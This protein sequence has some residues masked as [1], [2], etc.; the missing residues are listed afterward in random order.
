MSVDYDFQI[1]QYLKEH[2]KTYADLADRL[3]GMV[4]CNNIIQRYGITLE[5]ENGSD[6]DEEY[7]EYY[8]VFQ[9]YII[10]DRDA[11]FLTDYTN[12]LVYYDNELDIYV[13]GIT[14]F[15]TPWAGVPFNDWKD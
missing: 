3:N 14:H 10:Q 9:F 8:D 12:E 4:L 7:D 11:E 1:K 5:L 15:G 2:I 13:W 6:Y